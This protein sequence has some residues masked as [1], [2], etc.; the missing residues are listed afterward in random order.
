MLL[1]GDVI[2][3]L[4]YYIEA[5]LLQFVHVCVCVIYISHQ[6]RLEDMKCF[7]SYVCCAL[8]IWITTGSETGTDSDG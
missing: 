7:H 1:Y 8:S 5:T 6:D 2:K 4:K 3:E